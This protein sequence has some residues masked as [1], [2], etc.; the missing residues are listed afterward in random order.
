MQKEDSIVKHQFCRSEL[1][2][3]PSNCNTLH[4]Y[5]IIKSSIYG[6]NKTAYAWGQINLQNHLQRT[7][8]ASFRRAR[9]RWSEIFEC[10]KVLLIHAASRWQS[11]PPSSVL[12]TSGPPLPVLP[13]CWRY[14]RWVILNIHINLLF[15]PS[16]M[17]KR[18][19]ESVLVHPL[20][21]QSVNI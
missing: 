18:S 12:F 14:V 13:T 1:G 3:F 10:M 4:I 11:V 9:R 7:I 17:L 6:S 5:F 19:E 2:F 21:K 16:Y 20:M 8:E 15:F